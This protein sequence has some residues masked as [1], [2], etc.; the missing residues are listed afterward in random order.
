MSG[1]IKNA[2]MVLRSPAGA[3]VDGDWVEDVGGPAL[4]VPVECSVQ[5]DRG[6]A[7][8]EERSGDRAMVHLKVYVAPADL[9]VQAVKSVDQFGPELASQVTFAALFDGAPAPFPG[10]YRV[11][12]IKDYASFFSAGLVPTAHVM[13]KITREDEAAP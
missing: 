8:V 11:K 7:T 2:K 6:K 5:P 10:V 4:G 9:G 1:L 12:E 3:V 13:L